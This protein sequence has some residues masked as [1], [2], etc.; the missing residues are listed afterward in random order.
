M[1]ETSWHFLLS[2]N[3]G[4]IPATSESKQIYGIF[5]I[6]R[7]L[8]GGWPLVSTYSLILNQVKQN[9]IIVS[10]DHCLWKSS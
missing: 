10:K 9:E 7:L 1:N 8:A 2:E 4:Q 3:E 6:I 5:G